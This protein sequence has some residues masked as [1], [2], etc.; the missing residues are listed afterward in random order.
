MLCNT[1]WTI[2]NIQSC[3]VYYIWHTWTLELYIRKLH[4]YFQQFLHWRTPGFIFVSW[5][6]AMW[7][8]TLKHLLISPFTLLLLETSQISNQ[9]IVISDL[10]DTLI[11]WDFEVTTML[12]K[13]WLFLMIILTKFAKI[14]VL[15]F[16][17]RYRIPI[18]FKYN[19]DYNS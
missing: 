2:G 13:I 1:K 17:R 9:M 18:I 12:L 8:P 7:F 14:G 6:V 19:F 3:M 5:I 4:V 16:F 10:G 11:I 15:V